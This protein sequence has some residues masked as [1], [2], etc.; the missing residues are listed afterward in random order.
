MGNTKHGSDWY[1]KTGFYSETPVKGGTA[2]TTTM[3]VPRPTHHYFDL[4]DGGKK[5]AHNV[6]VEQTVDLMNVKPYQAA[7]VKARISAKEQNDAK[8]R[9]AAQIMDKDSAIE[10]MGPSSYRPTPAYYQPY[11]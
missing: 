3:V 6:Q 4:L 7:D 10:A 5:E 2:P 9:E 1:G 8:I 11:K